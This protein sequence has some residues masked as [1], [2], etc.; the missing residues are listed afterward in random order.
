MAKQHLQSKNLVAYAIIVG[1][2]ALG[3]IIGERPQQT[4]ATWFGNDTTVGPIRGSTGGEMVFPRTR[5]TTQVPGEFDFRGVTY[6]SWT[7]GEYPF[8][9]SWKPQ[10]YIDS[11]AITAAFVTPYKPYSGIGSFE[12]TADLVGSHPN[13][14]KGEVFVDLRYHPPLCNPPD[15]M[16]APVNFEGITITAKVMGSVGSG[17]DPQR[18]NG[19]QLFVK[20]E[21]WRSFYGDWQ[22]ISE[23]NWMTVTVTPRRTPP[24]YGYMDPGFDPTKAILL[25]LKI[26]VGTGSTATFSGTVWLDDVDWPGGQHPKCAT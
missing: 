16:A 19:F 13:K 10:T 6:V 26:G 21:N 4:W 9:T 3:L 15:C 18:P 25:G 24:P 22:N 11:Q 14:S 2:I 1:M 17:G 7:K 23:T 12:M 5:L 8:T 20:D